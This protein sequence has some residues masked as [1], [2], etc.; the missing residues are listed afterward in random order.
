MA[1][2]TIDSIEMPTPNQYSIPMQ[3]L[4]SSD[5]SR[6]E[7]GV[8]IRNRVRQGICQ[9]DLAWRVGGADAAK[10]LGAIV[11]D[12]VEVRYFDPRTNSYNEAEM[13]VEDR[14]C[15]LVSFRDDEDAEAN[16]WDVS[17]S[18]VQY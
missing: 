10:L 3:D 11:P 4:D 6:S 17:F 1:L 8:L 15:A 14:S 18:L 7:S 16:L 13:Y 2:I 9:L 5:S 12:K